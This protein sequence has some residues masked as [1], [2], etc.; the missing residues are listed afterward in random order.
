MGSEVVE[1]FQRQRERRRGVRGGECK[2]VSIVLRGILVLSPGKE[3][4]DGLREASY[5]HV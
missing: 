1:G 5:A 4:D 2:V 3:C